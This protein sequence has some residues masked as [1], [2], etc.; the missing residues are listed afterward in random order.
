MV[1]SYRQNLQSITA[2]ALS[3]KP[4]AYAA[5]CRAGVHIT[6]R[7]EPHS[8]CEAEFSLSLSLPL[9]NG[10]AAT[11]AGLGCLSAKADLISEA[12]VRS[13]RQIRAAYESAFHKACKEMAQDHPPSQR[14]SL[15]KRL[16]HLGNT[17]ERQ[18]Q[19]QI[20]AA[21]E[22]AI[23]RV[24][25]AQG[26]HDADQP[27]KRQT[28]NQEFVPL[29]EK[30]FEYN[31]Y[32]SAPDRT[33]LARKSMMTPRQIEVWFQ[34]HRN[35]AKKE[36][37]RLRKLTLDPLPLK[38]SFESLEK[39]MPFFVIPEAER[40]DPT[41]VPPSP[42]SED[43]EDDEGLL[44]RG[45]APLAS[46]CSFSQTAPCHAFPMIYP[47]T[48][49][50]DPFPIKAGKFSFP[51]PDW[52]RR[53][54][55]TRPRKLALDM[56]DF[57]LD[58]AMKLVI[59]EPA[60]RKQKH[61]GAISASAPWFSATHTTVSPAP[62]PA[63]VRATRPAHPPPGFTAP[64]PT[65]N[66]PSSR[67]HPFRSPSPFSHPETLASLTHAS[68]QDNSNRRKVARLP[69]RTPKHASLSHRGVS[70]TTSDASPSPSPSRSFSSRTSSFSSD[71][72][73]SSSSSSSSSTPTTPVL[74]ATSLP[75]NALSP[76]V[77]VSGLDFPHD[78][79]LFGDSLDGYSHLN[80]PP[81]SQDK[82]PFNFDILPPPPAHSHQVVP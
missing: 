12:F 40:V 77:S 5:L 11:L 66:A 9:P 17:L 50:Y 58:F 56:E 41:R 19:D 2:A 28:F 79:D 34:N 46:A 1:S 26:T 59:R 54:A 76:S 80:R 60:S 31:A 48:C 18:Y 35:R 44:S 36:G 74:S 81:C 42:D 22:L 65:V 72:S 39:K 38:L 75:E 49:D 8:S 78:D 70:P 52:V 62:H 10:I 57:I 67:L 68:P 37:K 3:L 69:R 45:S 21:K 30:Y 71:T 64:L 33:A 82:Q 63:L 20:L 4:P 73:S 51:K 14:D 24:R 32:P 7:S 16:K 6:P 15:T 61:K 55:T 53:P 43:D 47:P 29:L 23:D 25:G 27:A 13:A